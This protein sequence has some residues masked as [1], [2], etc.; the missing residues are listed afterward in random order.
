[1][2]S[3]AL[4]RHEKEG[5]LSTLPQPGRDSE[6]APENVKIKQ[7]QEEGKAGVGEARGCH[8]P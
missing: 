4:Q 2:R 1:M 8:L 3:S 6:M 5:P 7:Q